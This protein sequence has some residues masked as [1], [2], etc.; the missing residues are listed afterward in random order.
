MNVSWT[1]H[2]LSYVVCY[3]TQSIWINGS[4]V[5]CLSTEVRTESQNLMI[6]RI[7]DYIQ[8]QHNCTFRSVCV[9]NFT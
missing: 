4:H 2:Y 6:G 8:T 9:D 5:V 1:M 7:L 3:V